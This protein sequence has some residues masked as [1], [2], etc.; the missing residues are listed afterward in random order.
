MVLNLKLK[1]LK[2]KTLKK[3]GI[4]PIGKLVDMSTQLLVETIPRR[5]N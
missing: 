3:A 1:F 4:P 5:D 2:K